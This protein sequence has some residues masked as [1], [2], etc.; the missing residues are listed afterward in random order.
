DIENKKIVWKI[1]QE[2]KKERSIL[3]T[4]HDIDEAEVLCDRVALI[5]NGELKRVGQLSYLKSKFDSKYKISIKTTN[6][7]YSNEIRDL[8]QHNNPNIQFNL[9][10]NN[11]SLSILIPKDCNVQY[12]FELIKQKEQYGIIDSKIE[13]FSLK[14][15]FTETFK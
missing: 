12:I 8:I 11:N 4:T 2:I 3:L 7:Q 10:V 14:D 6:S 9:T 15:I 13:Q 1:I 5:S